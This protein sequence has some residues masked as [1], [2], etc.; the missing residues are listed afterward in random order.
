MITSLCF[1]FSSEFSNLQSVCLD[2]CEPQG[3]TYFHSADPVVQQ[4]HHILFSDVMFRDHLSSGNRHF[5]SCTTAEG[6]VFIGWAAPCA[7]EGTWRTE[8]ML[9]F[10]RRSSGQWRFCCRGDSEGQRLQAA[11]QCW[12]MWMWLMWRQR[13]PLRHQAA[14]PQ[15][16]DPWQILSAALLTGRDC[17]GPPQSSPSW[18]LELLLA[19]WE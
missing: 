19:G 5:T 3:K 16:A 12:T 13:F 10:C 6:G 1:I 2:Q 9:T 4:R 14:R 17:H 18:W 7:S 8:K 15:A 11:A